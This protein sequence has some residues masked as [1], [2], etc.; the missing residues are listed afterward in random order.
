MSQT[1]LQPTHHTEIAVGVPSEVSLSC[2]LPSDA[3]AQLTRTFRDPYVLDKAERVELI[4]QLRAAVDA[5]SHI[6]ELRIVLGMA[7]CVDF[8]AQSALEELRRAVQLDPD[9]FIAHLKYGEL[10]MRLRVC[11]QA[12]EETQIAAKL[13]TSPLQAELARRQAATIRTMLREGVE[14]GGFTTP[15]ARISRLFSRKHE[16]SRQEALQT[17]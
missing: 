10:L 14:R 5:E 17:R 1:A 9:S 8:Q 7:L 2:L 6:P 13:A 15:L 3:T 16:S 12:A 4:E 11:T